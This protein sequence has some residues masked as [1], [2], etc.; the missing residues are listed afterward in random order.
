M[1]KGKVDRY[2]PLSYHLVRGLKKYV[3]TE[4]PQVYLFY[5]NCWLV[6]L[7]LLPSKQKKRIFISVLLKTRRLQKKRQIPAA[8]RLYRVCKL[9]KCFDAC[10]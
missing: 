6:I 2:V 10:W 5:R 9:M 3:R 4:N 7:R 1:K 8:A